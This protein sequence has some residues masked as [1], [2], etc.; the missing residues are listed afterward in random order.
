MKLVKL[1]NDIEINHFFSTEYV[2]GTE[3][4]YKRM[5]VFQPPPVLVIHIDRYEM[6]CKISKNL[7]I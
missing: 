2:D 6:V 3:K 1:H 7:D 5:L 4:S